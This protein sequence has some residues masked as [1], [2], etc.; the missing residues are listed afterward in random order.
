MTLYTR[1][2]KAGATWYAE[3]RVNGVREKFCTKT[4]NK[5]EARKT[6]EKHFA[7]VLLGVAPTGP[8]NPQRL[9]MTQLEASYKVFAADCEPSTR[10]GNI[11]SLKA[12]RREAG[13]DD[14]SIMSPETWALYKASKLEGKQGAEKA[15]ALRSLRSCET[16]I[17]S[18]FRKDIRPLYGNLPEKLV[19]FLSQSKTKAPPVNYT[20]PPKPL[21]DRTWELSRELAALAPKAHAAF[22]M[23]ATGGLRVGEILGYKKGWV[24]G[25]ESLPELTIPGSEN[26]FQTKSRKSRTI[27]LGKAFLAVACEGITE[28][29]IATLNTWMKSKVGWT[30][31][32]GAH[33]LRKLYGAQVATG[34]G[35][36]VAQR[37]LGHSDPSVTA[38]YYADL[39]EVPRVE[40]REG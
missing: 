9:D 6:A 36:Y 4:S 2:P 18:L 14:P 23:A 38:A 28:S 16:K 12:A 19:Q 29:D 26:L 10:E 37:L 34:Y 30:T 21:I 25:S 40:V 1:S 32:K 27:P 31:Q 35:L 33:E 8:K 17:R 5:A 15:S 24:N 22:I 7:S 11:N 20:L 3:E 39:C 13:V